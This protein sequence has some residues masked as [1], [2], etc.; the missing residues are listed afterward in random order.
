MGGK[1]S[2]Q[3]VVNE[4]N[5]LVANVI[6]NVALFC[7][8]QDIGSQSIGIV[9]SSLATESTIFELNASCEQCYKDI[10]T[11]AT[12]NYQWQESLWSRGEQEPSV[13]KPIDSDF[14]DTIQKFVGC[15]KRCKACP[16]S[17]LSQK[18]V[19]ESTEDCEA[20]NNV[21]NAIN[22]KLMTG[23]TQKL[24]NNQDML[25][26]LAQVLG[27]STTNSIVYNLTNRISAKLSDN[28]ISEV[29]QQI[30]VQQTIEINNGGGTLNQTGQSQSTAIHAVQTFLERNNV[31]NTI[32]SEDQ[33][34]LLQ[35][36]VNDQNT[37][38]SL[39]NTVVKSVEYLNK[40]LTNIVGKVVF[41][42][43]VM[44]GVVFL[45]VIV[46]IV[47]KLIQRRLKKNQ[48]KEQTVQRQADKLPAFEAF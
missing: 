2:Q 24:V 20:F 42:V 30:N 3:E 11:S 47:T 27:A 19:I 18:T 26:P 8:T 40:L 16:I 29:K 22:Q 13:R 39:G 34:N 7:N 37:V 31:F 44:V 17:D 46:Y 32:F 36:L 1:L 21:K 15:A 10:K 9:C 41:A 45:G 5:D 4:T 12:S 28:I 23:I 38:S 25:S 48:L 14:Q 35:R 6:V 43:L 33:W